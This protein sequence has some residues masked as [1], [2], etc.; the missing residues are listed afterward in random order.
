LA[1]TRTA[2]GAAEKSNR[3][4]IFATAHKSRMRRCKEPD[5]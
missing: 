4:R 2:A 3:N 5:K 1:F